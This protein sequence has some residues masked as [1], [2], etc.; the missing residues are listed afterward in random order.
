MPRAFITDIDGT[1]TDD[2]RRLSTEVV[3]EMRKLLDNDIPII[4]ASGN[5]LCFLDAFSHMIGT[6]GTIIAEN[7]GVYRLGYLG[8]KQISG[9]QELCLAAYQKVVDEL[10]PKGDD[11]RLFSNRYRDSDIAFSRDAPTETVKEILKDM[12]VVVIDTGFAIH[13][14]VPGITKGAVFEKLTEQMG[15][16]PGD[17]LVA[18]DSINDVSMLKLGGISIA[19]A[20]ASPEAKL[21]AD[22]VMEKSYGEGT[23]EALRKYF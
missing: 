18:G 12:P 1:L 4:L 7:G 23:A 11:L 9:N 15:L 17:F 6:D 19:P 14:Q 20:N 3:D 2:R 13:L 22:H 5:T 16:A 8:K 21:A 10:Q